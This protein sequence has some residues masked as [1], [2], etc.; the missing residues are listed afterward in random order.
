M[1]R[2]ISISQI[3]TVLT[4][5]FVGIGLGI[6]FWGTALIGLVLGIIVAIGVCMKNGYSL[7][8]LLQMIKMG[9]SNAK[10]ILT[11][12]S[13]IGMLSAAWMASGTIAAMMNLGFEYLTRMNA[14]LAFF[15]YY[16]H[17]FNDS[18]HIYRLHKRYRYF[19]YGSRK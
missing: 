15:C 16:Q 17:N 3:I 7:K 2:D 13:L 6:V 11:I 5:T 4:I 1:K 12:M 14:L 19:F 10:V 18:W 9:A 8:E